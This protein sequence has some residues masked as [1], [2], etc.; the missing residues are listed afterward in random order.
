M[1]SGRRSASPTCSIGGCTGKTLARTWCGVHYR[2]WQRL[3]DPLA[4]LTRASPGTP[5]KQRLQNGIKILESGCW[6]W[7]KGLNVSGY[8]MIQISGAGVLAHRAAYTEWV[9]IIPDGLFV[10]HKCDN[11]PCINPEHLTTG[12]Q[13]DN[14]KQMAARGRGRKAA[15]HYDFE[16][17]LNERRIRT[18]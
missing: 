8:G 9:G 2:R 16:E 18:A 12:T 10:L 4:T 5:V 15:Q 14:M 3:G 13:D 1:V 17:V 6:V 7:T 11:P